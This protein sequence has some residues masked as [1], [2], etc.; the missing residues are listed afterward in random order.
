MVIEFLMK[1]GAREGS[2]R[3]TEIVYF[4]RKAIRKFESY[5]GG[6]IG[7]FNEHLNAHAV[8]AENKVITVGPRYKSIKKLSKNH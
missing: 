7:K 5:T 4:D 6:L 1:F 8:I 2:V 3:G